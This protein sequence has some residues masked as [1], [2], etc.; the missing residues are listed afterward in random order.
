ME[1]FRRKFAIGL[2]VLAGSVGVGAGLA[3]AQTDGTT[4]PTTE[5][6]APPSDQAPRGQDGR[7]CPEKGDRGD[8]G[9]TEGSSTDAVMRLSRDAI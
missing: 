5:A 3:A 7:D 6:P 4:P 8:G 9:S 2:A 1:P